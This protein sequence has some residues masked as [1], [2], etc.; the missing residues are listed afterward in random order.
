VILGLGNNRS[1]KNLRENS[2]AVLFCV[3][4][5]PVTFGTAGYRL[6]LNAREIQ[7]EGGLYDTVT[8]AIAKHAGKEAAKTIVAAVAFDVTEVRGLIDWQG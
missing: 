4:E 1:L 5:I 2:K 7:D 8:G 3:A 6:Y